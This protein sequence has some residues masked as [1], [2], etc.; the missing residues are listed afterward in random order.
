MKRILASLVVLFVLTVAILTT[1]GCGGNTA[2][3]TTSRTA[4]VTIANSAFDPANL[5]VKV[6]AKVTWKNDDSVSHQV[7]STDGKF[8]GPVMKPGSS[9][10][11]KMP[12][13]GTFQ[14]FCSIH[15]NMRGAIVVK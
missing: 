15:T 2:S 7:S 1:T 4:N 12:Q 8:I 6:G 9:W 10:S 11:T 13:A 5:T 14:Y 3:N